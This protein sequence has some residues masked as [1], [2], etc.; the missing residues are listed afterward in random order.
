MIDVSIECPAAFSSE[1]TV[2]RAYTEIAQRQRFEQII[3]EL[4]KTRGDL[5]RVEVDL[6]A[7]DEAASREWLKTHLQTS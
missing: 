6:K 7:M 1:R 5:V 2:A 3:E 4:T